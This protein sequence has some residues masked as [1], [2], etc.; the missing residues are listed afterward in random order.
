MSDSK[1]LQSGDVAKL[2]SGGPL[3]TVLDV[4]GSTA[5]I[6]WFFGAEYFHQEVPLVALTKFTPLD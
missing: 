3:L 5:K 2:K 4:A 1:A 6:G